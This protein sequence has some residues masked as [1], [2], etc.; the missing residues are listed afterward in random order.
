MSCF[1]P[2]Y[3]RYVPV[4]SRVCIFSIC[5]SSSAF[6]CW[7]KKEYGRH[8]PVCSRNVRFGCYLQH[9]WWNIWQKMMSKTDVMT[10]K[11]H[12]D[13]M[14]ESRLTPLGGVRGHVLAPVSHAEIPVGMQEKNMTYINYKSKKKQSDKNISFHN[15][16]QFNFTSLLG[17]F[18]CWYLKLNKSKMM[19]WQ[20][21]FST[22]L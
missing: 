8:K 21:S 16:Y 2:K 15:L 3:F 7:K 5:A 20:L 17:I 4:L 11:R 18:L 12:P 6:S 14:H 19:I 9:W 10:S 22:V 1:L 13:V